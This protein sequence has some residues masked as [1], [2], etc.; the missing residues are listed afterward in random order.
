MKVETHYS[1]TAVYAL[2]DNFLDFLG[3]ELGGRIG[4]L[5]LAFA[6]LELLL[7]L[8]GLLSDGIIAMVTL[9]LFISDASCSQD[10]HGVL[11]M[12]SQVK[13][14]EDLR[15]VTGICSA[16]ELFNVDSELNGI[17]GRTST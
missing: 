15:G 2:E 16:Q 6:S 9:G 1:A 3:V 8:V 13:A 12:L 4:V 5:H 10:L 17:A 14:L 11:V 7:V